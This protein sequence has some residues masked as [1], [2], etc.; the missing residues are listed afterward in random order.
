ML[1]RLPHHFPTNKWHHQ[2]NA[3]EM[4]FS[5]TKHV[6]SPT[7]KIPRHPILPSTNC[8][9]VRPQPKNQSCPRHS[10]A[11]LGISKQNDRDV[12][13][14]LIV[15]GAYQRPSQ[16]PARQEHAALG[17]FPAAS[18]RYKW[19]TKNQINADGTARL[20]LGRCTFFLLATP[21]FLFSPGHITSTT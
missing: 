13:Y 18:G 21:G 8:A 4:S 15:A 6:M 9:S 14:V 5:T 2:V 20:V 11:G 16:P 17:C 10:S 12:Q 7:G 19:G 3:T 1:P